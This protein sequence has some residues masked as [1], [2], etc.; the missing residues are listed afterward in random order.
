M[1]A[2]VCQEK[3]KDGSI[4]T[5]FTASRGDKIPSDPITPTD[6]IA[7]D[8]H[9]EVVWPAFVKERNTVLFPRIGQIR[10]S[11]RETLCSVSQNQQQTH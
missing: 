4:L 5:G 3:E 11:F 8:F 1:L 6:A 2:I 10:G 9:C 7:F